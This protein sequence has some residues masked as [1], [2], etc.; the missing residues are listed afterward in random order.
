M[1]SHNLE[2]LEQIA[3]VVALFSKGEVAYLG[4]PKEAIKRYRDTHYKTALQKNS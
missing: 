3:D 2:L 1:V 4:D